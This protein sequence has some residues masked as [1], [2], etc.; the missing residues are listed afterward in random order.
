MNL[1][2][3]S[4]YVSIVENLIFLKF[5]IEGVFTIEL[6]LK[7]DNANQISVSKFLVLKVK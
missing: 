6:N 2:T 4:K 1:L 7:D 5:P 3:A